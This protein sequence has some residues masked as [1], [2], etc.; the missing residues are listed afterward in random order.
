MKNTIHA[1]KDYIKPSLK[2]D[3]NKIII[4]VGTNNLR[5]TKTP[6]EIAEEIVKLAHDVKTEKNDVTIS[7]ITPRNDDLN[8]KGCKV[9]DLLKIQCYNHGIG[10]ID[11]T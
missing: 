5:S 11:N 2:Y 10:F 4:H 9:N 1:L 6:V 3:S 8:V 7:G